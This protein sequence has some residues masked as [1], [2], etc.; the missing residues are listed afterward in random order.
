MSGNTRAAWQARMNAPHVPKPW[1]PLT[2]PLFDVDPPEPKSATDAEV[3]WYQDL[4]KATSLLLQHIV[5]EVDKNF[6]LARTVS[7]GGLALGK[8]QGMATVI[9]VVMLD[10][11]LSIDTV[12]K[13][14]NRLA[15]TAGLVDY[16]PESG[17]PRAPRGPLSLDVAERVVENA[18]HGVYTSE[19]LEDVH[20]HATA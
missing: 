20:E 4:R 18:F 16:D 10:G 15:K 8:M 13:L 12:A 1:M 17:W 19:S 11:E 14:V 3:T 7:F 6:R 9:A 5:H 2:T